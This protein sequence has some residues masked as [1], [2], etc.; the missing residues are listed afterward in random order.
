VSVEF[1]SYKAEIIRQ[2]RRILQYIY[3]VLMADITQ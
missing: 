1:A 3:G 2:R